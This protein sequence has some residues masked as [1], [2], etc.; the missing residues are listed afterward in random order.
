ME[1]PNVLFSLIMAKIEWAMWANEQA[2]ISCFILTIGSM[3]GL[4]SLLEEFPHVR[5]QISIYSL[6]IS[7]LIFL[8]EYPRG[9]RIK[10]TNRL[11]PFQ[12]CTSQVSSYLGG[13]GSN[14]F[15]RFIL[16]LAVCVPPLQL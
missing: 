16:Y 14:Y 2:L 10:G 7:A 9:N 1:P 8:V 12:R 13:M 4:C 5:W 3:L 11:R 6:I 15:V